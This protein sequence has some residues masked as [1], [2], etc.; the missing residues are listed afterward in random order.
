[1]RRR[2]PS[3]LLGQGWFSRKKSPDWPNVGA[4]VEGETPVRNSL[5]GTT[6]ARQSQ[7]N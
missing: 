2:R 6:R 5:N 7:L 4:R 3:W 1:M